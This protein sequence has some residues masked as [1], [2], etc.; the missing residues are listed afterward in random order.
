MY[1]VVIIGGG[2]TGCSIA[3]ELSRYRLQICVLEKE[4][5]VGCGSTK[6]NSAIVHAG[7]DA[8]P[9]TLKARLNVE[10]NLMYSR[11]CRELQVPFK[12]IGSLVVA[13]SQEELAALEDLYER[14]R[15][16]GVP[17]IN[18][19]KQEEL[20]VLEPQIS[21]QAVAALYAKTAGIICPFTL[22]IATAENACTNGVEFY[23]NAEVKE[24]EALSTP[25]GE[26]GF[27]IKT[28]GR[29]FTGRFVVNAAGVQADAIS[30][31]AGGVDFSITPRRG[32]YCILDQ[33]QGHLAQTVIFQVPTKI[34]KGILVA[35]TIEGNLLIGPNAQN[36][37]DKQDTSTTVQ[38]LREIIDGAKKSV[39]VFKTQKTLNS[40]AGLR[41]VPNTGDFIITADKNVKG[42]IHAAGI[43]S[44]G[45]SSAP[46]VAKMVKGILEAEGLN[47]KQKRGFNPIRKGIV[48]FKELSPKDQARLAK[49]NSDYG[50]VVC[51][52]ET[53][54]E[55]EILEAIRRPLGARDL[56][57]VKRRTRAGMGRCQGGFCG[58]RVTEI[59]ARELNISVRQ[60]T[61]FG[62][63]SYVLGEETKAALDDDE[64]GGGV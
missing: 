53:V 43:E 63:S 12:P 10:G 20:R 44:P 16:N 47:C 59:L 40:F 7:Y 62:K 61:K 45:L 54:T 49:R 50:R 42:L 64:K 36:I 14:G 18:L 30:E 52:C 8:K 56:D 48:R 34:G 26:Y 2:I 9:G 55:G 15:K 29:T 21:D 23:F 22:T 37:E 4:S 39:P 46:A 19:V 24:V 32:E 60:V 51:R 38:G 11:I 58:P 27:L 13:F 3:R 1:D 35:P 41:S 57:G 6:A 31:M 33:D 5:D 28:T 17:E 25:S